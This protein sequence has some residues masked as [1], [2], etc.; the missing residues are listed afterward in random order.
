MRFNPVAFD[1][2]LENI[3]QQ[4]T[5]RK[6]Y[7][8]AC[9]NP[10]SGSPDPKHQLCS[11][12]GRLWAAPVTTV[13]GIA[14]QETVAEWQASGL[15]ESGDMV[16][17]I[18]QSSP[19][20]GTAG[21]FDRLLMLNSTDAFSQPL[22]RGAPAERLIFNVASLGRVFWLNPADRNQIVEGALPEVDAS[23]VLSWPAGG[24]PPPGASYSLTG[25]KYDEYFIFGQFP[26]DRNQHS[27]M[28]LPKRVV[29]RKWDLF[30]R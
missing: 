20:W 4:I 23:G 7:A 28:R 29:A 11:G 15:F 10:N 12:K 3:G 22:V 9:V 30:G 27:G 25:T 18:P 26:S 17:T 14:K 16:L 21:Q 24:G 5:W 19:M 8:C 13:C 2:H 6:S 1:R